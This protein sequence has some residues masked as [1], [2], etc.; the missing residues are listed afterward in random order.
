MEI[1]NIENYLSRFKVINPVTL[2]EP[3][4]NDIVNALLQKRCPLCGCKLQQTRDKKIWRCK[5]IRKDRFIIKDETL[6]KYK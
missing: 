6:K 4:K 3:T 2:F 5:S 1:P